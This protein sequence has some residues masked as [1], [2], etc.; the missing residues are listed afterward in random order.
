VI[1]YVKATPFLRWAGGKSKILSLLA[2]L[3]P[4]KSEYTRYVEPFLGSGA[5]FFHFRPEH[6]L[7]ADAN[8]HLINCYRQVAKRPL[9]VWL[10]LKT[11]RRHHSRD[12]YLSVRELGLQEGSP[13]ERAARFIYLNKSAFNGI[14]R[15]SMAGKF[16]VP[17]GPSP[18]GLAIPSKQRLL[19]ASAALRRAI[20]HA[21]SFE[22]TCELARKGDFVYLDPPYP[23]LGSSANFTHYT[24]DRFGPR[25]QE[26][27]ATAFKSLDRKGCL[28]MLSNSDQ[29]QIRALYR[30]YRITSLEV[31]RW[32]GSN[33]KRFQVDEIVV[34]NY[35][36]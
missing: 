26:R 29:R 1:A 11:H 3:A 23:P 35:R 28:V 32:L 22:I 27:V 12:Y 24:S 6:A 15:V 33:G 19:A 4:P 30:G 18:S 34:T 36:P 31:T 17:F 9:D 25:D 10:L 5:L 2:P 20:L 16:N 8:P 13:I 14:Y 7:L 21:A